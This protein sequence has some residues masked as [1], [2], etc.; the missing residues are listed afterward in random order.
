MFKTITTPYHIGGGYYP[1][2]GARFRDYDQ[3]N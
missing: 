3:A 2:Q 1:A